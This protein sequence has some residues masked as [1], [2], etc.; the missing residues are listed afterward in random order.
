[1]KLHI[2][3]DL[4]LGVQGMEHPHTDADAVILAGD[5]GRPASAVEWARGFGKPVLYVPGNHEFYGSSLDETVRQLHELSQGSAVRVLANR[6]IVLGGVRF[7]GSTLWSD[8]RIFP[9]GEER[10]QAMA[11]GQ[12]FMRDFSRIRRGDAPP[13]GPL[14]TPQD[15]VALFDA[16]CRWLAGEL[17]RPHAGP[18]VVVTHHAPSP[19]SIHPRFAGSPIN[20]CFVSDAEALV[21]A[22][23]ARLWVHG[24]THDS[25]DYRLGATRVLCNP[26][27]YARDGAVENPL[28]DPCLVVDV[29]EAA[30]A[31]EPA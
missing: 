30:L 11:Q 16:N 20:G 24:H 12:E 13:G 23:G 31:A 4:H 6:S 22:S 21:A 27:G 18:T 10:E 2:L 14:F 15:A 29:A 28:F 5:I 17:A 1:M 3:S 19:R 7:V 26:R 25:F 8:F 9:E